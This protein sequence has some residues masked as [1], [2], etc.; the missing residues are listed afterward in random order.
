MFQSTVERIALYGN[1]MWSNYEKL[2][3]EIPAVGLNAE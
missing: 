1:E 3:S 2:W